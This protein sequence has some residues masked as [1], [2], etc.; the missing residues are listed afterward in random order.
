MGL[1]PG[2]G[3]CRSQPVSARMGGAVSDVYLSSFLLSLK[4]INRKNKKVGKILLRISALPLTPSRKA[5]RGL[6]SSLQPLGCGRFS[7]SPGWLLVLLAQHWRLL[8][9][10]D[11]RALRPRSSHPSAAPP[12]ASR[13]PWLRK[14]QPVAS[15]MPPRLHP[16]GI[17]ICFC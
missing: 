11:F 6:C 1:F 15:R 8:A 14:I 13:V 10:L 4:S 16:V 2:Q 9:D 12:S 17:L 3:T 5:R 7:L